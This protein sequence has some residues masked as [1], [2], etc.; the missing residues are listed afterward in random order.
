MVIDIFEAKRSF[1]E[2]TSLEST[3]TLNAIDNMINSTTRFTFEHYRRGSRFW[4]CSSVAAQQPRALLQALDG[5]RLLVLQLHST[6]IQRA[7]LSKTD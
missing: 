5:K 4:L 3:A 2:V 6:T 1:L 7:S